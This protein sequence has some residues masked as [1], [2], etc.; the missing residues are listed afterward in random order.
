MHTVR[1]WAG[2]RCT[3]QRPLV[4]RPSQPSFWMPGR[5]LRNLSVTSLPS[6]SLRKVLPGMSSRSVRTGVRPSASKYLSSKLAISASWILPRLW[7]RR[8]TSSHCAS[9]VTMRQDTRL[10]SAVPHST[11]F[12]PP[13]FMAMLPPTQEASAEV[14]STANT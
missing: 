11:A 3:I 7:S 8:V 6:P 4:I 14:G 1:V 9:G 12:L 10:S 13:A 2:M 5:P